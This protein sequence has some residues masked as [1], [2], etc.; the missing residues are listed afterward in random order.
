MLAKQPHFL[1]PKDTWK[2]KITKQLSFS[3]HNDHTAL[4]P[5]LSDLNIYE[6]TQAYRSNWEHP[7]AT[8]QGVPPT[9][10]MSVPAFGQAAE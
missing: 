5:F 1:Q 6:R 9:A 3:K 4:P 10:R 8:D 7:K 2:N